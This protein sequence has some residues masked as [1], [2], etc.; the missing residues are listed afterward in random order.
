MQLVLVE[1]PTKARTLTRFLGEGYVVEATYG[2]VRDLPEK[3][4]GL[5]LEDNFKPVYVQTLKQKQRVDQ[6]KKVGKGV[7]SVILAT[8]PDREGEAIAW[9]VQELLE[10][11]FNYKRI[12]FHES[13]KTAVEGAMVSPGHVNMPL[14]HTQQARRVLDRIVGYKLSPLLW[15]KVRRGLS[16]GRVQSIALRFIVDRER[17]IEK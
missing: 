8:D 12:V 5:D 2:H 16:A 14:V 9:H 1:S 3:K 11:E 7:K 15:K 17:E 13:K 4:I 6:I 10:T